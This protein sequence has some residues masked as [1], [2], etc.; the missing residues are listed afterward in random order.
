MGLK[1]EIV[2]KIYIIFV[3]LHVIEK[4]E[5]VKLKLQIK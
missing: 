1:V 3:N 5:Q 4:N 2:L